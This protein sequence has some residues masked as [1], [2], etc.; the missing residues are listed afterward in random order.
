[1]VEADLVSG[2]S[3]SQE[4]WKRFRRNRFAM[5]GCVVVAAIVL[6][7]IAGPALMSWYNGSTY[8]KQDLLHRL[9]DPSRAHPL[10]TDV[11]GRDL[12][13]R[14]LYGSRVSLS[15]GL[16]A[17]LLSVFIGIAYGSVAGFFGG[18]TDEFMMRIVDVLYS[19]PE[20]VLVA[21]LLALFERN[22]LLLFIAL[23]AVSWLTMARIVRGQV[24]SLKNE[25]YVEAARSIGASSRQII[26]RH[27]VPNAL[28]PIIAYATLTVPSVILGEGFLSFLGLGVQPPTPSWGSLASEGAQ[29]IAVHPILM[30]CPG[31]LMATV[32]LS[33]NF[34]GEG[35]RDALDPQAAPEVK[36]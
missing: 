27:L 6:L 3:P 16:I 18:R 35:L 24:M 9:E 22:L 2:I 11:L 1:M 32:L 5:A 13:T 26:M 8:E 4:A 7:A 23:G 31:A 17:T 33:L 15:I 25:Q 28:G 12:L 30:I 10:G 14:M 34:L 19:L 29:A 21:L 20:I 36:R